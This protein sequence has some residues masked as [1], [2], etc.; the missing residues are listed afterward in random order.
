MSAQDSIGQKRM[1]CLAKPSL[2]TKPEN[3][4]LHF[5]EAFGLE[6]QSRHSLYTQI[7][8]EQWYWVSERLDNV[9][10]HWSRRLAPDT[11]PNMVL[12]LQRDGA[13]Q[14]IGPTTTCAYD[15]LNY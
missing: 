1:P 3:N 2:K 5:G 7:D 9:W 13:L 4:L 15:S 10:D 11:M 6:R 8:L 12:G 14:T